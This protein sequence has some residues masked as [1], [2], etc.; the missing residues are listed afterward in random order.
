MGR[1][2]RRLLGISPQE[3]TFARRG[4]RCDRARVRG[5]LEDVGRSF[6]RGYHMALETDD[7]AELAATIEAV[8]A[9]ILQGFACEGAGMA[10][11]LLDALTPWRRD[12][13]Q[14]FLDGP[15]ASQTYIVH[16]GAGWAL[17][18]LPISIERLCASLDPL[19]GW[20]ALDGYGFHQGFF[21]APQ[22]IARQ[23]VP[24]RVRG[25]ARR[26]FDQG[27]GRS[28]WF[29]EGAD[30][31]RI[32]AAIAAFPAARHGDLWSGVGLASAYAGDGDGDHETLAALRRAAGP[33]LP[34]VAQGAAFAAA[35]RQLAGSANDGTDLACRI[36]CGMAAEDAAAVT[37]R[38]RE[39]A[40]RSGG[41][42]GAAPGI[43]S[44]AD[45][46]GEPG[47]P[48]YEM[49]R[50]RIQQLLTPC[51]A[52][53]HTTNVPGETAEGALG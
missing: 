29:V 21:H 27:L 25:Y 1:V 19:L 7:V 50:R 5:H 43:G 44:P 39:D 12:R 49:W 28:L 17:A 51:T 20:L 2:S 18:R 16:V 40:A 35:A 42:A 24:G 10:L 32:G 13:L 34:A 47:V 6:V 15:A 11:T 14:R 4:F 37:E 22:A 9:P 45:D 26:A 38:A 52:G 48:L 3:V 30:A 23:L 31:Q 33:H 41:S 46:P 8:I 36:L 53:I